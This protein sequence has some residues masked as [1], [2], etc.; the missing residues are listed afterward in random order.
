[1]KS[2][3]NKDIN[4]WIILDK[5]QGISSNQALRKIQYLLHAKKA[6]HKQTNWCLIPFI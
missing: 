1:M 6:G 4:G 5:P 3:Y 2:H